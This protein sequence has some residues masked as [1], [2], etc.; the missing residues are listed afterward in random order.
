[1]MPLCPSQSL[2]GCPATSITH[3]NNNCVQCVLKGNWSPWETSNT[4]HAKK[5]P[6]SYNKTFAVQAKGY[7]KQEIRG[8]QASATR[9]SNRAPDATTHCGFSVG[10][11]FPLKWLMLNWSFRSTK[12]PAHNP[13]LTLLFSL[14][15]TWEKT[16]LFLS[17]I[18]QEKL[19]L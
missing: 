6:S 14:F 17:C 11:C 10:T 9:H 13:F 5:K 3:A 16:L 12:P 19:V 7:R 15:D 2:Y 8:K 1:M 18:W 4:T